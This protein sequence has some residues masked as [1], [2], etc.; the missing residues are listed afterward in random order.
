MKNKIYLNN[1]T[2]IRHNILLFCVL[3]SYSFLSAQ[4]YYTPKRI[5]SLIT[6][7]EKP[8]DW[9]L[10][11]NIDFL[12]NV[13]RESEKLH[14]E[15]GMYRCLIQI[16]NWYMMKAQYKKALPYFEKIEN[17]TLNNPDNLKYKIMALQS[18]SFAFTNLGLYDDAHVAIDESIRQANMISDSE[19]KF[20][21]LGRG[22]D[23]KSA[24]YIEIKMPQ[25]SVLFYL[26]KSAAQYKQIK[27]TSERTNLLN[28]AYINMSTGFFNA[29]K[30]DSAMYYSR[31]AI[32]SKQLSN[33]ARSPVFQTIAQIYREK[34]N[35]DSTFYYYKQAEAISTKLGNPLDLKSIYQTLTEMYDKSGDKENALLY[36][37]KYSQLSDSLNIINK[38]SA[39]IANKNIK[40]DLQEKNASQQERLYKIIVSIIVMLI[41][42]SL[43]LL[44]IF[45]NY[46]KEKKS[47]KEKK[48]IIEEKTKELEKLQSKMNDSFD[49]VVAL[50]KNNDSAFLGRFKEVYPDFYNKLQQTYPDILNSELTF[51]AYL[52]LNFST[53]EIATYTFTAIKSVQNR[54]NRLRKRLNIPSDEDIYIWIDKL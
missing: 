36:A 11:K 18:K 19:T 25:D 32:N 42:I 41:F 17:L 12:T 2:L 39:A 52:K 7:N 10:E 15:K 20:K 44:Y 47:Q 27:N 9:S 30:L 6:S 21:L 3:F 37:K 53:K 16:S 48:S 22:L 23:I 40:E 28:A 1:I 46:D 54:K 5:D 26:K 43:L 8:N 14:Y 29:K 4:S 31:K 45:R 34:N 38:Q 50:A 33:E 13:Y 24:L 35:W 51:C 49:E